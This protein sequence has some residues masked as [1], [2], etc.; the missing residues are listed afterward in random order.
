MRR[1]SA[2]RRSTLI[3]FTVLIG[4]LGALNVVMFLSPWPTGCD[5]L[6]SGRFTHLRPLL[7][8]SIGL[9]NGLS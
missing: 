6:T 2:R 8:L 3:P 4:V 9:G 7:G 1:T 5:L